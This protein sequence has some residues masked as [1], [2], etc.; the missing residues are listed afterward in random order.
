[1]KLLFAHDHIFYKVNNGQVYSNGGLNRDIW[2]RYLTVFDKIE[3]ISRGKQV[4]QQYVNNKGF[5]LSSRE[6]VK[7]TTVSNLSSIKGK[8]LN[9]KKAKEQLKYLIGN[10]DALVAR[11]P[12]EIGYLS[13][14]V[15][16]E[17]NKPWVVE[18]VSDTF[19]DLWNYGNIKGKIYAPISCY[20]M[21]RLVNIS[22]YVI[23]VSKVALQKRYPTGGKSISCSNVKL[24]TLDNSIINK[25]IE[26]INKSGKRLTIGLI[27]AVNNKR[28]G[29]DVA[30]K[31]L[32]IVKK[33]INVKLKILGGGDNAIW[34]S[35]IKKYG[36]TDQ[37]EFCGT[38]PSGNPVYN[39]L[40]DI[41]VYIQ[42]SY[43]E[44]LPRSIIEAMSRGC[45]VIGSSVGAIPELV[46]GKYRHKP[47][48]YKA[49]AKLIVSSYENKDRLKQ[50]SIENFNMAREYEESYLNS[51]RTNFLNEFKRKEC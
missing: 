34:T 48:D 7:F 24:P 46:D 8:L 51:I 11:I 12:S 29:I 16:N 38:L 30:I 36:L 41:D 9:K 19:D 25:R 23:Y 22:P 33:N 40:D 10:S 50:M 39:W 35:L 17:L 14:E 5:T 18:V 20:K 6:N 45:P 49:L 31:A 43:G 28:K 15:A 47:G 27:G 44:G 42:P 4:K 2:S 37:V 21:K 1:M 3:V 13:I 32:R 26:M